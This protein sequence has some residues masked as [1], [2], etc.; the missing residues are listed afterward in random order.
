MERHN[1]DFPKIML[2]GFA[3]RTVA[4]AASVSIASLRHD[5]DNPRPVLE[6]LGVELS[7]EPHLGILS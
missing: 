6:S 1:F 4:A 5:S 3:R 2:G 7:N